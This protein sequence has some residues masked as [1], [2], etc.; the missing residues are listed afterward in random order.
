MRTVIAAICLSAVVAAPASARYVGPGAAKSWGKPGVSLA[1]YRG[2][3]VDCGRQAAALDVAGSNPAE[4][5]VLASRMIDNAPDAATAIDAMRIASPERN[6]L[7]VGDMLQAELERC[8][9]GRGYHR[10]KLTSVQRHKLA[11]L[12]I[13]SDARHAYL[14]SLAS[15]PDVLAR[16]AVD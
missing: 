5:L 6:F 13:G 10:F 1:D 11:K 9:A 3:A 12:P 14:H 7:K 15:N 8:L 4:A 2:D 16:Q